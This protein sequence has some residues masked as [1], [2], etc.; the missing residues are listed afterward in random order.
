MAGK[1]DAQD[2]ADPNENLLPGREQPSLDGEHGGLGA[3]AGSEFLKKRDEVH[4][5]GRLGETEKVRNF[6]VRKSTDKTAQHI[7]FPRAERG[8][9]AAGA[10]DGGDRWRKVLAAGSHAPYCGY[11]IL[12]RCGLE[13][14]TAG[15]SLD[16]APYGFL[17]F[18][19]GKHQD[20]SGRI[21]TPDGGNRFR[22]IELRQLEIHD[23]DVRTDI[24]EYFKRLVTI[25]GF[26]HDFKAGLGGK[27]IRETETNHEVI[28]NEENAK[29]GDSGSFHIRSGFLVE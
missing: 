10:Q 9:T 3:V 2:I 13:N 17:C 15:S 26:T 21:F 8:A 27:Q 24:D 19:H 18:R 11:D 25:G 14:I 20:A 12:A 28:V 1:T 23:D 29:L 4:L 5:D 16:G 6:L 7:V 22:S